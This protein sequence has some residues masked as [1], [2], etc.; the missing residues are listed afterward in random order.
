L[1]EVLVVADG[2]IV[3]TRV[4]TT[5][6]LARDTGLQHA[7]REVD[8]VAELD[9]LCQVA[10]E[11]LAFVLDDDTA[12]VSLTELVDDLDLTG[13]LLLAAEDAEVLEHRRAEV[14]P[15]LPRPF[16]ARDIEQPFQHAR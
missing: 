5:A 11:D 13:H 6:L 3:G 9:R 8:H 4:S 16:P 10:V 1:H 14:V 15:D 7:R 2:V 12:L